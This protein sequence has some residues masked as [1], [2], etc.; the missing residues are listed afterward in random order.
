MG[1]EYY[2]SYSFKKYVKGDFHRCLQVIEASYNALEDDV[3]RKLL[4]RVIDHILGKSEIDLGIAWE[5]GR[6]IRTGAKLLD[7][8]LVNE[9]LS[10][11]KNR[12]YKNVYDPFAKGLSHFLQAEKRPEL[13]YDVI[14]DMYESLEALAKRVTGRPKKDLSANAELFIKKINISEDY[15]PIMKEYVSY[16]NIFRHAIENGKERP[17]LSVREVESFIYL[18]GLF[19][20]LAIGNI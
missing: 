4:S 10:W 20:R 5:N 2:P 17:S 13:L 1:E 7:Q 18:T 6:F 11:L 9:P 3:D 15:K 12:Q 19:I 8:E 14:T 16:A